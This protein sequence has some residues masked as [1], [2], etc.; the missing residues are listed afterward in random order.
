MDYQDMNLTERPRSTRAL[1]RTARMVFLIVVVYLMM[2]VWRAEP[3]GVQSRQLKDYP[4]PMD[5]KFYVQDFKEI[6]MVLQRKEQSHGAGTDL[7]KAQDGGYV[8]W[9]WPRDVTSHDVNVI[10]RMVEDLWL[11]AVRRK[12]C[13]VGLRDDKGVLCNKHLDHLHRGDQDTGFDLHQRS[14]SRSH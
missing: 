14:R 11:I 4:S 7:R 10:M 13:Q 5:Q 3:L 2:F 1:A 9:E 8:R 6:G 12:R